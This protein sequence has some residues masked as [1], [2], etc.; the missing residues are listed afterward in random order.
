LSRRRKHGKQND[1]RLQEH[2]ALLER[3]AAQSFV[4]LRNEGDVLPL[5]A[6]KLK[7][8]AVIGPN[9]GNT[10]L[11]GGGSSRVRPRRS[12]SI[13]EALRAE[14]DGKG[15]E[16]VHEIGAQWEYLPKGMQSLEV[17]GLMAMGRC[18][19]QGQPLAK[20]FNLLPSA[21]AFND[22]FLT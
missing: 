10:V 21:S 6:V 16:L 11:Q 17:G 3:A 19:E 4:L 22:W 15:L 18:D 8:L 12:P 14:F 5:N 2:E 9:A 20:R 7:K 1:V 13:L